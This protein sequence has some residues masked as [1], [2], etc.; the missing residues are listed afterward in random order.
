MSFPLLALLHQDI[1]GSYKLQSQACLSKPQPVIPLLTATQH[2]Q[3][4]SFKLQQPQTQTQPQFQLQLQSQPQ[5]SKSTN[6]GHNLLVDMTSNSSMGLM[7]TVRQPEDEM[8]SI[9][10]EHDA[11]H[12]AINAQLNQQINQQVGMV[13]SKKALHQ[14]DADENLFLRFLELDPPNAPNDLANTTSAANSATTTTTT[15]NTNT[16]ANTNTTTTNVGSSSTGIERRQSGTKP[17]GRTPFTMTKRLSRTS[18]RGFGFSIVWTHPPRVEKIEPG[19]SADRCGILPGDYVIFVDKH[20]VVTMPEADVLNLIRSQGAQLTLEIFRRGGGTGAMT[21]GLTNLSS[22]P[23][24]T[25]VLGSAMGTMRSCATTA[26][27][28]PMNGRMTRMPSGTSTVTASEE[29]ITVQKRSS[30]ALTSSAAP[31]MI[32]ITGGV[33]VTRPAT[34]CSM[35]TTSSIE[36]A[37]RRLHLPQVTFSKEVGE[38]V[39][40]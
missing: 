10:E 11:T 16:T 27:T 22:T 21:S 3:G 39:I 35:G 12:T 7:A 37:K 8:T 9:D 34:A 26:T 1:N 32:A 23:G 5:D 33:N 19:L 36:A 2:F 15:G 40:V 29:Q 6:G 31:S 20:N 25:G 4:Q 30:G 38:G 13:L 17:V 14:R 24:S 18:D 28:V